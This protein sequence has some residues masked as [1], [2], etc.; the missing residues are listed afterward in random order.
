MAQV[1]E[2]STFKQLKGSFPSSLSISSKK[3]DSNN[4][5][6]PLYSCKLCDASYGTVGGVK[7]HVKEK[8]NLPLVTVQHYSLSFKP[9]P[10]IVS[11][12]ESPLFK[13]YQILEVRCY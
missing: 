10:N 1:E 7:R 5:E 8:H 3:E 12:P 6:V 11:K 9:I 13:C 4:E 2:D